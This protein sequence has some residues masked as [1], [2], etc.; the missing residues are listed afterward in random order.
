VLSKHQLSFSSGS[1]GRWLWRRNFEIKNST[2][3]WHSVS[4]CLHKSESLG[5]RGWLKQV[6]VS[7]FACS[8]RSL[9]QQRTKQG[10]SSYQRNSCRRGC[11]SV[12]IAVHIEIDS[13]QTPRLPDA[14]HT[15]SHS[16]LK[17]LA[18]V[19]FALRLFSN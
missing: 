18:L 15:C 5:F 13:Y 9:G 11:Q 10:H 8:C 4:L 16:C 3:A 17:M 12:E 7:W 14:C 2:R 6:Q 1:L 19:L